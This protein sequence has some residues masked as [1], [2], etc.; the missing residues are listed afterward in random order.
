MAGGLAERGPVFSF[1]VAGLAEVE[2]VAVVALEDGGRRPVAPGAAVDLFRLDRR[3][4]KHLH[5]VVCL[6]RPAV[7]TRQRVVRKETVLA[8]AETLAFRTLET[9]ADY[10]ELVAVRTSW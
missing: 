10:R 2:G 5:L 9:R 3:L 6:V 1:D 7:R 4:Q 8:Q